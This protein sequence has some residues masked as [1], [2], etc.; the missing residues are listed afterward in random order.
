MPRSKCG[1]ALSIPSAWSWSPNGRRASTGLRQVRILDQTGSLGILEDNLAKLPL[2]YY[3]NLYEPAYELVHVLRAI[4]RCKDELISPA[5]YRAEAEAALAAARDQRCRRRGGR[6][7]GAR[8]RR[9]LRIYEAG[10]AEAADA[11]DFGDLV[12]L[13]GD[14][15]EQNTHVKA[16]LHAQFRHVLV[17]EYQD[18]NLASARLLRAICQSGADVWVVADQ[19]Q[20]IYRFR[21]AEP[22][23]VSRFAAE[24]GGSRHS[25]G[26][27][28]SFLRP[29]S[30]APSRLFLRRD[31]G[32]RMRGAGRRTA[33]KAAR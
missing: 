14:L 29:R 7:K 11:V 26:Q 31:A 6:G 18:V 24:F 22:T 10:T 25:L 8:S 4:S 17:D 28:L 15:V 13:A 2:R 19:R 33:P 20:S 32:R 16:L 27:Q 30:S 23:N 21:G 1:S 5:A 9:D 3:Q 12:R